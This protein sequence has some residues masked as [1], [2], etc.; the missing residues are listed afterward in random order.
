MSLKIIPFAPKYAQSF[1]EL[2]IAWLEKYFYVE[3]HDADLM[4]RCEQ[5]IVN[6]GGFIFFAQYQD[7]IVGCYSFIRI[8]EGVYELGKMAVDPEYQGLKIGQGLMDHAIT[9]AKSH[10]WHKI[11]LYSNTKLENAIYIYRKYGFQEIDL[12]AN[13]PYERSN[14]KMELSLD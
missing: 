11:V 5:T 2:N 9:Y 10:K 3:P 8:D 4:E 13:T 14:I 1:K 7:T 12:E 6:K